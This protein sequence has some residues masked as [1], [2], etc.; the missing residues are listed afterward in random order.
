[1]KNKVLSIH[2]GQRLIGLV[3]V[4]K[5]AR[6]VE[7]IEEIT[8]ETYKISTFSLISEFRDKA[9]LILSYTLAKTIKIDPLRLIGITCK[10]KKEAL[11]ARIALGRIG[12]AVEGQ[13]PRAFGYNALSEW[14]GS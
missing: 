10:V 2:I 3:S 14:G 9:S 5:I 4:H 11:W 12:L 6:E 7:V 13:S 8:E 1:V